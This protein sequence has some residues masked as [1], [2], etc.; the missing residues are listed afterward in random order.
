MDQWVAVMR[1]SVYK[2]PAPD[3]RFQLTRPQLG[4]QKNEKE[5]IVPDP[6]PDPHFLKVVNAHRS[7]GAQN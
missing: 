6:L 5:N 2:Q 1:G 7:A 3:R 4:P